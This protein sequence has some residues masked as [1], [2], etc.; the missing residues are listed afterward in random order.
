[1]A[2]RFVDWWYQKDDVSN[3]P[4]VAENVRLAVTQQTVTLPGICDGV[5]IC[6]L[7]V[8]EG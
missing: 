6:R 4:I 5:S 1:M 8:S 7:V 3:I 2:F